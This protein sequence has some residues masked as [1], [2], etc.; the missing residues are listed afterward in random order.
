MWLSLLVRSLTYLIKPSG[1]EGFVFWLG[2]V[3]KDQAHSLTSFCHPCEWPSILVPNFGIFQSATLSSNA[4]AI[5]KTPAHK[6]EKW[7][8]KAWCMRTKPPGIRTDTVA[9]LLNFFSS[10]VWS[11]IIHYQVKLYVFRN[12]TGAHQLK[13]YTLTRAIYT[14]QYLNENQSV[15]LEGFQFQPPN[16]FYSPI[17]SLY[18]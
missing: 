11:C 4:N 7:R 5:P 8:S 12:C 17:P 18:Q 13:A 15:S 1:H 16:L 10:F 2:G 9:I 6:V 14:I 3:H